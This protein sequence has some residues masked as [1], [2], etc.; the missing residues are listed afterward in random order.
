[1]ILIHT[2]TKAQWLAFWYSKEDNFHVDIIVNSDNPK[3]V[4]VNCVHHYC[5]DVPEDFVKSIKAMLVQ[6]I[7][8]LID[9]KLDNDSLFTHTEL[10]NILLNIIAEINVIICEKYKWSLPK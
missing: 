2:H 9:E 8:R 10:K 6:H 4:R 5:Q 3:I 7:I 1:M